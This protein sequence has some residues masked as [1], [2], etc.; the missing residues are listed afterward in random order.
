VSLCS[1][2]LHAQVRGGLNNFIN[3]LV[4]VYLQGLQ[5]QV[6]GGLNSFNNILVRFV[7]VG[8]FTPK[9]QEV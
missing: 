4:R 7:L 1:R 9:Q 5:V 8:G 3:I 6:T 2:G